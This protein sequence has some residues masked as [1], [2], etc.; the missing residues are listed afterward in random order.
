[1]KRVHAF[2]VLALFLLAACAKTNGLPVGAPSYSTRYVKPS[3]VGRLTVPR[4]FPNAGVDLAVPSV[5]DVPA[6]SYD[7]AYSVCETGDPACVP[8]RAPTITLVLATARQSGK[9]NAD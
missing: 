9:M 7:Q 4:H 3:A 6:I 1:M 5:S 8:D 2:A